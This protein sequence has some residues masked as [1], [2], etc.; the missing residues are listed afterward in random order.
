[1][2]PAKN[3]PLKHHIFKVAEPH[4]VVAGRGG[5]E[6]VHGRRLGKGDLKTAVAKEEHVRIRSRGERGRL[7]I[8]P[9]GAVLI[10]RVVGP[11]AR[12]E[13][14]IRGI[15]AALARKDAARMQPNCIGSQRN[16]EDNADIR[17]K[18]TCEQ[19]FPRLGQFL[20]RHRQV[21]N[22]PLHVRSQSSKW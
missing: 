3:L 2:N 5:R 16:R 1:M 8:V 17:C 20:R 7:Q 10:V 4:Q 13:I 12:R 9:K 21:Q 18:P 11:V 14:V 15:S 19:T 22:S 6:P